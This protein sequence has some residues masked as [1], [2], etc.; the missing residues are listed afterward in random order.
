MPTSVVTRSKLPRRQAVPR[1]AKTRPLCL[2]HSLLPAYEAFRNGSS[3][4]C[5]LRRPVPPTDCNDV[6]EREKPVRRTTGVKLRGPVRSEGHVSFNFRAIRICDVASARAS[7]SNARQRANMTR[8]H[9]EPAGPC[10]RTTDLEELREDRCLHW[11]RD[12]F[13]CKLQNPPRAA[14]P[15]QHVPSNPAGG[16]LGI[17]NRRSGHAPPKHAEG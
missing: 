17:R 6:L 7:S 15:A 16:C 8:S 14:P 4:L 13:A 2:V 10:H 3:R 11:G 9:S 12:V 5:S 1:E